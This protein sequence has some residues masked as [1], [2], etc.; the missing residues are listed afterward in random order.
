MNIPLLAACEKTMV[1]PIVPK[2]MR[3]LHFVYK[4]VRT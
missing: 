2:W 3:L 4:G 1:L